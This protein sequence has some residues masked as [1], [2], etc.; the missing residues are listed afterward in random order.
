MKTKIKLIITL[1]AVGLAFASCENESTNTPQQITPSDVNMLA[2][3]IPKYTVKNNS[4]QRVTKAQ[5]LSVK[6]GGVLTV[7]NYSPYTVKVFASEKAARKALDS[8]SSKPYV[9][10]KKKVIEAY[11]AQTDSTFFYCDLERHKKS[12]AWVARNNKGKH[13]KVGGANAHNYNSICPTVCPKK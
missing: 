5:M 12:F 1:L 10:I 3:A 6:V 7:L 13:L 4:V 11:L 9:W 8:N 2:K